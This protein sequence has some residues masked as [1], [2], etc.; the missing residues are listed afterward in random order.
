MSFAD[1]QRPR[2]LSNASRPAAHLDPVRMLALVAGILALWMLGSRYGGITHDASVY[3]AQGLRQLQPEAFARDLFF[4]QGA[5]DAYSLFGRLYAP[6]VD[7]LGPSPAAL[8]VVMVGHLAFLA[9]AW[10][11][12]G[13]FA[14]GPARWW[15]LALLATVS[16]FYGGFG[17]FRFAEPFATA[18]T[19]AEPLALAALSA[20]LSQRTVLCV[21]SLAVAA[22]LHPL[23]AAPAIG[24][25]F[26][27]HAMASPRLWR[28]VP[29]ALLALVAFGWAGAL[30]WP[31]LG[32]R[33]DPAW[34]AAIAQRTPYIFLSE[35]MLPDAAR[36]LWA[37]CVLWLA[38]REV[39]PA[40]RRLI[41]AIAV[42]CAAG[43][44]ATGIGVDLLDHV[45]TASL[46]LWR[47]HWLLH[48]AAL[49]L[50]PVA[51][52]GLWK[53]GGTGCAAAAMLAASCCFGRFELPAAAL[54]AC[55]AIALSLRP[56]GD[57]LGPRG[58][59]FA[60]VV[61]LAAGSV[62]L[63]F[64]AQTNLPALYRS[65]GV[66]DWTRYLPAAISAGMLPLAAALWMSHRRRGWAVA[67]SV[68]VL[69]GATFL[70]DARTPWVRA[71]ESASA[72]A[73][74]FKDRVSPGQVVYW[75]AVPAP[76]WLVLR[77]ASWY[78]ADQGAG[79][80]FSPAT[81]RD[82]TSRAAQTQ[83]V[84][85]AQDLCKTQRD[86]AC[87]VPAK[88][89]AELCALS[90]GPDHLVLGA[91]VEGQSPVAWRV[92]PEAGGGTLYLHACRAI[93]A[94][95]AGASTRPAL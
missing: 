39:T 86:P 28:L 48:L 21:A 31:D 27:W 64:A 34:R 26:L 10:H 29:P 57:D 55:L 80:V 25:A 54:L 38:R 68:T 3:L 61:A 51:V 60:L 63:M 49:L 58:I 33:F 92:P 94:G 11:F 72:Q 59:S 73:H 90:N 12:T 9:A 70:W 52:V 36:L 74:P 6:L 50:L 75:D 37:A 76:A 71:L 79:I 4:A 44:L 77:R 83:A 43:L 8:L 45:P 1:P 93:L 69:A 53:R 95:N 89:A 2:A 19:L 47:A 78:S 88:A 35:W 15:S 16:G 24:V 46:Q 65:N 13:H 14:G 7:T 22:L 87:R 56:G 85:G 67:L 42:V 17:V 41:H 40:V 18:R 82:F 32:A 91:V 20:M 81:A 5:Q 30:P 62:G 66:A 84:R 23:V